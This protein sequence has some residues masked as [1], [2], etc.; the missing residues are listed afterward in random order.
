M[1]GWV[2]HFVLF[3]FDSFYSSSSPPSVT[4]RRC[5]R[6]HLLSFQVGH[7]PSSPSSFHSPFEGFGLDIFLVA[8]ASSLVFTVMISLSHSHLDLYGWLSLSLSVA[9][10]LS[11]SLWLAFSQPL[12][13]SFRD[14]QQQSI[15]CRTSQPIEHETSL[16]SMVFQLA[17]HP[18]FRASDKVMH[19][20]YIYYELHVKSYHAI[21]EVVLFA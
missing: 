11:T 17:A 3:E 2:S 19:E 10:F 18:P 6:P 21:L 20:E 4:T 9:G 1:W 12:C 8:A 5:R 15:E 16:Q 14:A 7:A 13:G